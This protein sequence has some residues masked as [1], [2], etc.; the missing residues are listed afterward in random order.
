MNKRLYSLAIDDF[1]R[2]MR[3]K[4]ITIPRL[5]GSSALSDRDNTH[6]AGKQFLSNDNEKSL[7]IIRAT[8]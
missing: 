7:A 1:I 5:D 8:F 4:N 2:N 3:V 6:P